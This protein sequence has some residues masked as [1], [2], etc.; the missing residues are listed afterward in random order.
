ML[1]N[2]TLRIQ[3]TFLYISFHSILLSHLVLIL[4]DPLHS[5][6]IFTSPYALHIDS[7]LVNCLQPY[8]SPHVTLISP[9]TWTPLIVKKTPSKYLSILLLQ[10]FRSLSYQ[11][12]KFIK[13]QS[14]VII[15]FL[16]ELIKQLEL[17][18]ILPLYNLNF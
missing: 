1:K 8:I 10:S 3:V 16:F 15:S 17:C 9:V 5:S 14:L 12:P 11:L 2:V 6:S 18:S 4:H 13:S 7:G